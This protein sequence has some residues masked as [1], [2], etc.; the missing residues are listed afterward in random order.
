MINSRLENINHDLINVSPPTS[1][2]QMLY[3]FLN[4]PEY[5]EIDDIVSDIESMDTPL[6]SPFL[7]SDDKSD[8]GEV[9]L[10]KEIPEAL[11]I[12]TWTI[13]G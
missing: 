5:L 12:F 4:P 10:D 1:P 6:V 2:E 13:L 11:R 7:D 3:D 9:I 8:D